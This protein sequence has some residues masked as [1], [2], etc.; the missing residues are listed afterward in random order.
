[1]S[2]RYRPLFHFSPP[3]GW[4][5]DPN[6]LVYFE[7]EYHL[8]Y[9]HIPDGVPGGAGTSGLHWGHAVSM[10]LVHWTHLP[11]ALFPDKLGSVYSGSVVVDRDDSSGFFGGRA[12]L[13]AIFTHHNSN[14][15][16]LGPEVQSIAYSGDRGRNWTAYAHNPVIVNPGVADFRDPKVVW[17]APTRLWVMVV[18]YHADRVHFATSRDLQKWTY[19]G[20]FGVG[21]GAHTGAWECPDLFALPVDG[22]AERLKW[23][24]HL[25]TYH[26]TATGDRAGLQYFVGDFDGRR[27]TDDSPAHM[28][29]TTDYGR[30]NYAAVTWSDVPASDGR[31]IMIGWMN[32]WAYARAAP[33]E[34]WKGAMT[35]PRELRLQQRPEGVRLIQRP[36]IEL[37]Q[38]RGAHVR[39]DD[40]RI[41]PGHSLWTQGVSDALEIVATLRPN[42]AAECGVRVHAGAG[43]HTSIGYDARAA[44]LFVDRA[45]S[46]R[47][48]F[49]PDFAGRHGS[50]LALSDGALTLRLYLDRCSVE[51]F[52]NDGETVVTSLIFPTAERSGLEF[53]AVGGEAE[54]VSLDVYQL[55]S[56]W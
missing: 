45:T 26:A 9:Q 11:V 28:V 41:D 30:D 1:M 6:G 50:P 33:T 14:T 22:D 3:S 52:G 16:P 42:S 24:L 20:E 37:E 48:A 34:A 39:W 4:T 21:H 15:A 32:D 8:F 5:N 40:Q 38:L 56:S 46:G 17:H 23:V 43:E 19:V 27:F 29:L 13:V 54:F 44:V 12:G 55:R 25:S 2:D 47:T 18:T 35:I 51:A 31:R 7:G 10:D 49:S 36:V 53:Y